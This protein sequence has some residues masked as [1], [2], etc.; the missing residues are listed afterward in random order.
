MAILFFGEKL[1]KGKIKNAN[2]QIGNLNDE[3]TIRVSIVTY[4]ATATLVAN[5]TQLNS[6]N[7][8]STALLGLKS[9]KSTSSAGII[10]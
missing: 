8:I 3:H 7:D 6:Q 4:D 10:E 9:T 1:R 2:F 5:M